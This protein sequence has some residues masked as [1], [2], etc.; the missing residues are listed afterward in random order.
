MATRISTDEPDGRLL[1]LL[2]PGDFSRPCLIRM[3]LAASRLGIPTDT[4]EM[5][6]VWARRNAGLQD[7]EAEFTNSLRQK[8]IRAVLSYTLHG[9]WE[10]PAAIDA[11]G[12]R[13]PFFERMGIPHLMWW[14]D[15]PQWAH[16]KAA[17]RADLQPILRSPNTYHF[18]KSESAAWELREFLRWPN[19]LAMPV[20][21]DPDFLRPAPDVR[22]EYD[23]VTIVGSMPRLDGKLRLFL[24]QDDPD[25][26]E[27]AL[28]IAPDVA[29]RLTPIWCAQAPPA[30]LTELTALGRVWIDIRCREPR[31]GASSVYRRI[32][33]DFPRAGAWLKANPLAYFAALTEMWELFNWQR[34]FYLMYL[35][36]CFR[37]GVFGQDWSSVGLGGSKRVAY[38]DQPKVYARGRIALNIA[39]AGDEEGASHKPF[40]IAASGVAMAHIDREG[41]PDCFEPR[42][43][44]ATFQTPREAREVI[45]SLLADPDRRARMAVAARDR[46][47]REHTWRHRVPEM[48]LA[49]G[50]EIGQPAVR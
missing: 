11:T 33:P 42:V 20:A 44:C 13:V 28:A 1:V 31:T 25:V 39:Q 35:A 17:L 46:L 22:P 15:H 34:T 30:L 3:G 4:F 10:W 47:V 27:M 32:H 9:S 6:P 41:L 26:T 21:E 8:R 49:A 12:R 5:A 29:G 50:V 24:E 7:G 45:S 18:V 37:V 40:Q 14:T 19:V 16:E 36:R 2:N 43:E 48:L 38:V 23:V